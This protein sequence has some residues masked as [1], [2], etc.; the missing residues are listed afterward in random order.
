MRVMVLVVVVVVV[1]RRSTVVILKPA[2]LERD[3]CVSRCERARDNATRTHDTQGSAESCQT[4]R[5]G[6]HPRTSVTC[7][8]LESPACPEVWTSTVS[9]SQAQGA[10]HGQGNTGSDS[11]KK[12]TP[13]CLIACFACLPACPPSPCTRNQ[14]GVPADRGTLLPCS[15]TKEQRVGLCAKQGTQACES[16]HERALG[17][18]VPCSAGPQSQSCPSIPL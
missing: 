11:P 12:T 13:C 15:P 1:D 6:R 4:A 8:L 10:R 14:T 2:K 16:K 17:Q 7:L 3:R 5:R 9:A 18:W